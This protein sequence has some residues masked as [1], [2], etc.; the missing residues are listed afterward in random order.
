VRRLLIIG[1]REG[2][3]G[4]HCAAVA[5]NVP[6]PEWEVITAGISGDEDMTLEATDW[7]SGVLMYRQPF[8]D[9]ICTVG[10]ND[11]EAGLDYHL[12]INCVAPISLAEC[13][14]G[15]WREYHD[16]RDHDGPLNFVAISSNSAQVPRSPSMPYCASKAALSMAIRVLGRKAAM[17]GSGRVRIWCYEPGYITGTPMSAR[18]D[19]AVPRPHRIPSGGPGMDARLLAHRIVTDVA[20]YGEMM[21]ATAQR[22]D[23]GDM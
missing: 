7:E 12:Q 11:P 1:A 19:E 2:S 3:L 4:W 18:L 20:W 23:M 15:G 8:T 17:E 16:E 14:L 6:T 21:Q 5:R 10:V 9:V 13:W 22:I